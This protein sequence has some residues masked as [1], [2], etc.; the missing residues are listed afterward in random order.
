M[1]S[2]F[3]TL[4]L[5]LVSS[6]AVADSFV[7]E[8][9]R[10]E[11]LQ[12]VSAG[13][14]FERLPIA[15]GD[16]VDS[17]RL[18]EVSHRLFASG[19]FNDVKLY[20]DGNVLIFQLVEL[21]T[22]TTIDLDGN[23]AIPDD[24][25]L[26]SLKN[27]G[28][29][30]GMVFKRST[31]DRIA[32]E[33]ERQYVIQGRYDADINTEVTALPRNRVSLK[34]KIDEGNVASIAHINIVG[35]KAFSDEQLLKQLSLQES[36][37]WSWYAGDNK[38]SR[39]KLAADQ[40]TLRS[41]YYD[42]GYLRFNIESTQVAL[43]PGKDGVYITISVSE[44]EV[45]H[46]RNIN[47]AGNLKLD[48]E[49]FT[50]LYQIKSGDVFSRRKVVDSSESMIRRLGNDGYTF[51]KVD[52]N[53]KPD[54]EALE[55]DI[56]F[57]VEPGRRTYVRSVNFSGNDNTE[58]EVLRR[59]MVQME[60]GWASTEKI[61]SGKNRL[62]QLG[63]FKTVTVE[64]PAVPGEDDLID[65]NYNVEEQLNGSLNFNIGYA[66]GSG[67]ILGASVSQ[68]NFLGT[69]NRMSLSVQKNDTTQS[70]NFSYYNPYYTIDGVSRGYNLF[71]R[72]TDYKSLSTVS[73]YQTNSKGGNVT[74]GYPISSRQRLSASVGYTN[75]K[76]FEGSTV[77][78][79]IIEFMDE[80]GDTFDEYS[81]GLNWRYNGLNKGM[82]PTAG[83]EQKLS[84]DIGVPGSDL[85]SYKLGYTANYYFPLADEWSFRIRTELG[86]G[87]GYG[88]L[89]RLP[90]FK[91]YRS[92]GLGSIRGYQSNSLGPKG[93]PEYTAVP[94]VETDSDGNVV[95]ETD[96]LGLPEYD[97]SSPSIVYKTDADGAAVAV[98][99]S[100]HYKPVYKTNDD[101]SVVTAPAYYET[102]AALG[103]NILVESSLELIFPLPFIEDQSSVRSL[104]FFDA[105]NTF[106]DYCYS[107][108]DED[109]PSLTSHPYC[110]TGVN[111]N[112]IRMSTGVSL[113]WITAIG[114][115]TFVYSIPLNDQRNDKTEGFEFSLGQVF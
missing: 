88:N 102:P 69:G 76:M 91:N 57:F 86:Y 62:N 110:E 83:M 23:S 106:T 5:G 115:L 37:F 112:D 94:V 24:A 89:S 114:P 40:E 104:V 107:P 68:N 46:I 80:Q 113:T 48:E 35:N 108:Y 59:E 11:G 27:A 20:R 65:V 19:L 29:S 60:G 42:R 98:S 101:G 73:D 9:I 103:G 17:S 44:G 10:L 53:P 16:S 109:I 28:L 15:V 6:V 79:E 4:L 36:N 54:D 45:Y 66:G 56:T 52:G 39:E 7:V 97:S 82:F 78:A 77:P 50:K 26:D 71:Y 64:T 55:V 32:L 100:N 67:M 111:L 87:N 41:W 3:L 93:L 96:N 72:E 2:L 12:R 14:V 43:A 90:F 74:F 8:D 38:Y 70:Y 18:S 61:E 25:L 22:I 13:T 58:D 49:E 21:P 105:G 92:G 84:V 47:L 33:L 81:V 99:N 85:T 1:R 75:T 95:Y 51:A 34:I 63:F 30:E 31:L